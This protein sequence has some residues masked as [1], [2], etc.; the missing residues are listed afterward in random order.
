MTVFREKQ[1][2]TLL[3]TI[4]ILFVLQLVTV[5][6]LQQLQGQWM[7][8]KMLAHDNAVVTV[9]LHERVPADI[10]A[11]AITGDEMSPA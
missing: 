3:F 9:L 6:I 8:R 4:L 11:R 1:Q 2:R 7:S 10:C 5:F